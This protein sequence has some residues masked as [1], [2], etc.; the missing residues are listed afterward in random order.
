MSRNFYTNIELNLLSL[1]SN[2]I[3]ND[4]IKGKAVIRG[5]KLLSK[6]TGKYTIHYD[7]KRTHNGFDITISAPYD[8]LY[9]EL[10]ILGTIEKGTV[11]F[12]KSFIKNGDMVFDVGANIGFYSLL[13]STS[14]PDTKVYSFEPMPVTFE[15][16]KQNVLLNSKE[17]NI[18]INNIALSDKDE[19]LKIYLFKELHHGYSSISTQ[20]RSDA[21]GFDVHGTTLDKFISENKINSADIIKIDVEGAEKRVLEGAKD[22]IMKFNPSILIEMNFE[23]CEASGYKCS[24]LMDMLSSLNDYIL[25][26]F[27]SARGNLTKMKNKTDFA[28]GDNVLFV[29][30]KHKDR[31]KN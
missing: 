10:L 12:L 9:A 4:S 17:N 16:L 18:N 8:N 30:Q 1:I 23:T 24:E 27:P 3:G 25:Y 2:G 15:R 7:N 11:N 14:G 29:S 5:Y 31:I 22:S 28:H 13:F 26:K 20:G 21:V 6:S 19:D